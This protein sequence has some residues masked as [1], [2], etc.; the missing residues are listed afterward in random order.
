MFYIEPNELRN[1]KGKNN[2]GKQRAQLGCSSDHYIIF[3]G[4]LYDV[5]QI[6]M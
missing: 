1:E 5:L 3:G 6:E 4:C 2:L